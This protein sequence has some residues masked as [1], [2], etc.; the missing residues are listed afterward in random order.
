MFGGLMRHMV[1]DGFCYKFCFTNFVITNLG[2]VPDP[3]WIRMQH[4]T[5]SGFSEYG[6][7][8]LPLFLRRERPPPSMAP[9]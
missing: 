4:Q 6:S 1:Y 5:R 9:F 7:E 8:T 2:L 3:D